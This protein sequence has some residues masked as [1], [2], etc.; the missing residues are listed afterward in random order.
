MLGRIEVD[1]VDVTVLAADPP[2]GDPPDDEVIARLEQQHGGQAAFV[3]VELDAQR[4]GLLDR[5]REAVEQEAV[6]SVI[7]AEPLED[8]ADDH[9]VGHQIT[10][11]HVLLGEQSELGLRFARRTQHV[12]GRDVRQAEVLRQER[13][14]GALACAGR[15]QQDQIEFGHDDFK[16]PGALLEPTRERRLPTQRALRT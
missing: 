2:P 7:V 6:A 12:A 4:V 15:T 1:V 13:G 16:P 3:R 5:P 11:V 14:L 10:R 9:R 8:H